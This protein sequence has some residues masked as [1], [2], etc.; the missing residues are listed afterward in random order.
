MDNDVRSSGR[1]KPTRRPLVT[2][3][4]AI[5]TALIVVVMALIIYFCLKTDDI[6][7]VKTMPRLPR[8]VFPSLYQLEIRTYFPLTDDE[9]SEQL[10]FTFDGRLAIK[11]R[12]VD[13]TSSVTMHASRITINES[14]LSLVP[15]HNY[16]LALEYAGKLPDDLR[17]FYRTSYMKEDSKRWLLITQFESTY[18]RRAL[19]CFDE[20]DFKAVF[21]ASLI[22]PSSTIALSN[23]PV[24]EKQEVDGNWTRTI[25]KPT[26]PMSTYLLAFAVCD[27]AN[28]ST[29]EGVQYRVWSRHS[30]INQTKFALHAAPLVLEH[31][32]SMFNYSFPL[33]KLDMIAI[34]DFAAGAMENWGL[35][36]FREVDLLLNETGGPMRVARIIAHELAH[37]WFGNLVT[38]KWWDSIWLNEGF[39]D[40]VSFEAAQKVLSDWPGEMVTR[41]F[42]LG[43]PSPCKKVRSI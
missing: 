41:C 4:V 22:H 33:P 34:P 37:Q 14:T 38:M 24:L 39:A 1:L 5:G 35:V 27:Y 28:V 16:T 30:Q 15:G 21:N 26:V 6:V 18:A 23:M 42:I 11:I 7:P 32:A 17:G 19:P 29:G 3:A 8:N 36:T 9:I 20:P 25:F 12:C 31:F 40:Y 2:F 43:P 10:N 13:S